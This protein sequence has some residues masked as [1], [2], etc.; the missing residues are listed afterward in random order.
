M[1]HYS[2][3]VTANAA[4]RKKKA[5]SYFKIFILFST[6]EM[7]R[8]LAVTSA[9]RGGSKHGGWGGVGGRFPAAF[10]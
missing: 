4:R 1:Q 3:Y 8:S 6:D 5:R 10:H 7:K 2:V 9:R